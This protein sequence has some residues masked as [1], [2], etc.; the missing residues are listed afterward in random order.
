MQ[1]R[2]PNIN[3]RA[4]WTPIG[5]ATF[6]NTNDPY[7]FRDTLKRIMRIGNLPHQAHEEGRRALRNDLCSGVTRMEEP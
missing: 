2:R 1:N 6:N 3:R 7:I 5:S 4:G